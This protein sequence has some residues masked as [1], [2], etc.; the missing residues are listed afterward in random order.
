MEHMETQLWFRILK[1]FVETREPHFRGVG[2]Y[3]KFSGKW[4]DQDRAGKGWGKLGWSLFYDPVW[5]QRFVWSHILPWKLMLVSDAETVGEEEEE[6]ED[7]EEER[8]GS[9]SVVLGR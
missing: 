4:L 8:E 9:G 3:N 2:K 1:N 7:D 5:H 6:E